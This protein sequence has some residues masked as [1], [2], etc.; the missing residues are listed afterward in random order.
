MPRIIPPIMN[1]KTLKTGFKLLRPWADD[2]AEGRIRFLVR[3]LRTNV[4]GRVGIVATKGFDSVW[5][6]QQKKAGILVSLGD[7]GVI[8]SVNI[9]DCLEV[10]VG[11]IKKELESLGGKEYWDYYPKHLLRG[12]L[13][14]DRAFIW[15]LNA[16]RKWK[17][18]VF[19]TNRAICWMRLDLKDR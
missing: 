6:A 5:L 13:V 10:K 4:R 17:R 16:A 9:D 18:S 19:K 7:I 15:S 1:D 14:D 12:G 11:E 2:V 3:D 8:G